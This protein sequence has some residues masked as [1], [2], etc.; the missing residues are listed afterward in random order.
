MANNPLFSCLQAYGSVTNKATLNATNE[1]F[2]SPVHIANVQNFTEGVKDSNEHKSVQ[3]QAK[4]RTIVAWVPAQMKHHGHRMKKNRRSNILQTKRE[5]KTLN[6]FLTKFL[7]H[8]RNKI[9]RRTGKRSSVRHRMTKK[10]K[11]SKVKHLKNKRRSK[12][13]DNEVKNAVATLESLLREKQRL[14]SHHKPV[15]HVIERRNKIRTRYNDHDVFSRPD[16]PTMSWFKR[17]FKSTSDD[18]YPSPQIYKAPIHD[19]NKIRSKI[20]QTLNHK[21]VNA[22]TRSAFK[23]PEQLEKELI[24]KVEKAKKLLKENFVDKK[25]RTL[26]EETKVD[27][28]LFNKYQK[29]NVALT[30]KLGHILNDSKAVDNVLNKLDNEDVKKE[31]E[32]NKKYKVI[33]TT[34][35]DIYTK[36]KEIL[37][38]QLNR[39]NRTAIDDL[40]RDKTDLVNN[41]DGGYIG[42]EVEPVARDTAPRSGFAS[43][44]TTQEEE[45]HSK[46]GFRARS[47][48]NA[49]SS[50]LVNYARDSATSV[51]DHAKAES[52]L[53]SMINLTTSSDLKNAVSPYERSDTTSMEPS[54]N[55]TAE[56]PE[57]DDSIYPEAS[58]TTTSKT[59]DEDAGSGQISKG[60]A[61]PGDK[62]KSE[63]NSKTNEKSMVNS[64]PESGDKD[65]LDLK[66]DEKSLAN[67]NPEDYYLAYEK[68]E[69]GNPAA[70]H[71]EKEIK[72]DEDMK[73]LAIPFKGGDS[74][75]KISDLKSKDEEEKKEKKEEKSSEV[76]SKEKDKSTNE[77]SESDSKKHESSTENESESNKDNKKE[78]DGKEAELKKQ[79]LKEANS[80]ITN[81]QLVGPNSMGF[82]LALNNN[83]FQNAITNNTKEKSDKD[84]AKGK[85][86]KEA[87]ED[88]RVLMKLKDEERKSG[89]EK[90]DEKK[91]Q[92]DEKE[93]K[94]EKVSEDKKLGSE[95]L[96]MKEEEASEAEKLRKEE[97]ENAANEEKMKKL[98]EEEKSQ[99]DDEDEKKMKN[100]DKEKSGDSEEEKLRNDENEGKKEEEEMKN[101]SEEEKKF[102]D[103]GLRPEEKLSKNERNKQKEENVRKEEEGTHTEKDAGKFPKKEEKEE[104]KKIDEDLQKEK[105]EEKNGQG[106]GE[107]DQEENKEVSQQQHKEQ[108]ENSDEQKKWDQSENVSEMKNAGQESNDN[109][110]NGTTALSMASVD[111]SQE[112]EKEEKLLKEEQER[113][114]SEKE[115]DKIKQLQDSKKSNESMDQSNNGF[116][117]DEVKG[118]KNNSQSSGA[119][120]NL[121]TDFKMPMGGMGIPQSRL[122]EEAEQ[123]DE[124]KKAQKLDKDNDDKSAEDKKDSSEID[125]EKLKMIGQKGKENDGKSSDE[126]KDDGDKKKEKTKDDGDKKK[127][128]AQNN[129][130]KK[131]DKNNDGGKKKKED[132]EKIPKIDK[133]LTED[134]DDGDKTTEK[135][136]N[137]RDKK[138]DKNNDRDEK[139]KEDEKIAKV[140]KKLTEDKDDG[141]KKIEKAKELEIEEKIPLANKTSPEY[142]DKGDN[143]NKENTD[144][145]MPKAKND[146]DNNKEKMELAE[147]GKQKKPLS[148][149][150]KEFEKALK[151]K[152]KEKKEQEKP[153]EIKELAKPP[154]DSKS[155]LDD[156]QIMAYEAEIQKQKAKFE[157]DK[158]KN[159]QSD[160]A[161]TTSKTDQKQESGKVANEMKAS[162]EAT[163]QNEG[164]GPSST[165]QN[166]G[167]EKSTNQ[168]KGSSGL[169]NQNESDDV[170]STMAALA[171]QKNKES[172]KLS[173]GRLAA[174]P[175]AISNKTSIQNQAVLVHQNNMTLNT[176]SNLQINQSE[177]ANQNGFQ[178]AFHQKTENDHFVTTLGK[179][180]PLITFREDKTQNESLKHMVKEMRQSLNTVD[181][182]QTGISNDSNV[183]HPGETKHDVTESASGKEETAAQKIQDIKALQAKALKNRENAKQLFKAY[184]VLKAYKSLLQTMKNRNKTGE[185]LKSLSKF[186]EGSL[187]YM[188]DKKKEVANAR[189]LADTTSQEQVAEGEV[190]KLKKI[191]EAKEKEISSKGINEY[192]GNSKKM[193][194]LSKITE[195]NKRD[196]KVS[197][198]ASQQQGNDKE[199]QI[200]NVAT[201]NNEVTAENKKA[202]TQESENTSDNKKI[203]TQ[204][205]KVT[206]KNNEVTPEVEKDT[207]HQN[208]AS[209]TKKKDVEDVHDEHITEADRERERFR[210]AQMKLQNQQNE[211]ATTEGQQTQQQNQATTTM[212]NTAGNG[213]QDVSQ[214]V[215]GQPVSQKLIEDGVTQSNEVSSKHKE[216]HSKTDILAKQIKMLQEMKKRLENVQQKSNQGGAFLN[217]KDQS[218]TSSKAGN[219]ASEG[220]SDK[221]S[222]NGGAPSSEKNQSVTTAKAGNSPL[223]GSSDKKTTDGGETKKPKVEEP[224]YDPY[225]NF[226]RSHLGER[227]IAK[228]RRHKRKNIPMMPN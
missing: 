25:N 57:T 86:E 58:V 96:K 52:E 195:G 109:Q 117:E 94:E 98:S 119:E 194:E 135:A 34:A 164:T 162:S 214:Q 114:M 173:E 53:H 31:E 7:K 17:D 157:T 66:I 169:A 113:E 95:A 35:E 45:P 30:R 101:A 151:E 221:K 6:G 84:G 149:M 92:K 205:E 178:Q 16:E 40:R 161:K 125:K 116:K 192:L 12:V 180:A 42:D 100:E 62:I 155:P 193:E 85:G 217:E 13:A 218:E 104:R 75:G 80:R 163:K 123:L 136:Q 210:L 15:T 165:N 227:M 198:E 174:N 106:F 171:N 176:L 118:A 44:N 77:D 108:G 74:D 184:K 47:Y 206:T 152:E 72:A 97:E 112:E 134:K 219:T 1:Q 121:S 223:E 190:K 36:D 111:G 212:Q 144:E 179:E 21:D 65:D 203:S 226:R 10:R 43:R 105:E 83:T 191:E 158:Q 29:Q 4:K 166:Q 70:D 182:S 128:K 215:S 140:D 220:T 110:K 2:A 38:E 189:A 141:D 177:L 188:N 139:K 145:K 50:E 89:E 64:N 211:Q 32:L 11:R 201:K 37:E 69:Y 63:S 82:G 172:E 133:K 88:S 59:I 228:G 87:K 51:P 138:M 148:R 150:E 91:L 196:E 142:K 46:S 56:E 18:Y 14:T 209:T 216:G 156:K 23:S 146:G 26:D 5:T 131:M 132:E 153:K 22:Q 204:N 33:T 207:S 76:K 41:G 124:Q 71:Q 213:A 143:E 126:F 147:E 137:D 90:E 55:E 225:S 73:A 68:A 175:N 107:K 202:A 200:R 197:N 79:K 129:R 167:S 187:E 122:L 102:G 48:K 60:F 224:A 81:V 199:T 160:E 186:T 208:E 99:K 27:S 185:M 78:S 28:M 3:K 61:S 120:A 222:T 9:R 183:H 19:Q 49:S 54:T 130:D 67:S 154:K 93:M 168:M 39:A 103:E 20:S 8:K 170:Y 159:S 181:N 115:E 127:E 24:A